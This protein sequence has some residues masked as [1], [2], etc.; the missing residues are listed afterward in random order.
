MPQLQKI[1]TIALA[2]SLA[3]CAHDQARDKYR[4]LKKQAAK[5]AKYQP[6]KYQ[7]VKEH[8]KT[9]RLVPAADILMQREIP[10][11]PAPN[12]DPVSITIDLDAQ[13]AWLYKNGELA[14]TSPTCTGKPGY[15]TPSGNFQVISKHKHW[16]ST[17]YHV[18]MPNFLRLNAANGMIGLHSGPVALN[19]SSHGCIRLTP[20][21]AEQFFEAAPVGTKVIVGRRPQTQS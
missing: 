4:A 8:G 14:L 6:G 16:V 21:M 9:Y 2:L 18:P 19:P 10:A 7:T 13:R 20:E 11:P 15:E 1:L 3:A 17:L 5:Q 12:N